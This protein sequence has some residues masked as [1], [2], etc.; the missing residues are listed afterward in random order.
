MLEEDYIE[1]VIVWALVIQNLNLKNLK[2]SLLCVFWDHGRH[3][4]PK[5]KKQRKEKINLVFVFS[6]I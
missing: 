1:A 6:I 3:K 2:T 5:L 4:A